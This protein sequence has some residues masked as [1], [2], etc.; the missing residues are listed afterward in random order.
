MCLDS[1]QHRHS[2][3]AEKSCPSEKY[4]RP[5]SDAVADSLP[6]SRVCSGSGGN[7]SISSSS[8]GGDG[9]DSRKAS[10]RLYDAVCMRALNQSIGRF[11]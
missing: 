7:S 2:K 9:S 3:E 1:L 11:L 6:S 5:K 8:T 10:A 4:F